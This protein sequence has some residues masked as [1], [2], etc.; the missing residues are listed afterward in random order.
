MNSFS[1]AA[2]ARK[3]CG[4]DLQDLAPGLDG[5]RRA[6]EGVALEL[7]ELRIEILELGWLT[8]LSPSWATPMSRRN[9]SD[10]SSHA[11]ALR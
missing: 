6:H 2:R 4:V 11:P 9:D 3:S 1:S 8:P 7:A 5:F 10:S